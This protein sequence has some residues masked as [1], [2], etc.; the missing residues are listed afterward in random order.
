MENEFASASKQGVIL[1]VIGLVLFMC[2]ITIVFGQQIYRSS[3][4]TVIDSLTYAYASEIES[5]MNY[6][7]DLPAASI[8]IALQKNKDDVN[9]ISGFVH[10][11]FIHSI[12]DLQ[13]LFKYQLRCSITRNSES[14]DI[15]ISE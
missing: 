5:I 15:T 14:Y 9:K 1:M 10:G 3:N 2:W 7:D 6:H 12:E 4:Q 13:P 11:I 8:Y